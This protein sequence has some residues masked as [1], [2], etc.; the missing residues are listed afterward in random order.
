M[1]GKIVN[2]NTG[3]ENIHVYNLNT[4]QGTFTNDKGFFKIFAKQNDNL[5]LTS[6]GFETL[7][8]KV[9]AYNL[10]LSTNTIQLK[11]KDIQLDEVEIKKHNL[12][13]FLALDLKQ[14]PKDSVAELVDN[15]VNDIKKMDMKAIINMP[16]GKDELHLR[17]PDPVIIPNSFIGIGGSFGVGGNSSKKK[18]KL[19]LELESK[20]NFPNKVLNLLGKDFFYVDLKI[21]KDNYYHFLDYCSYKNIE[22]L[23]KNKEILAT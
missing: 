8:F 10:G 23:F 2:G 13:G 7:I 16:V 12:T 6:V 15:L 20:K 4:K 18:N 9:T 19:K 3:L 11:I 21:P 22:T 17:K 5:Q 14:T 1:S